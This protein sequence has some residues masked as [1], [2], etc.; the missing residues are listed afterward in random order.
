MLL[1]SSYYDDEGHRTPSGSEATAVVGLLSDSLPFWPPLLWVP[2]FHLVCSTPCCEA[3]RLPPEALLNGLRIATC[4]R[5]I[6]ARM[7]VF[8]AHG[9]YAAC[10]A[11]EDEL[12]P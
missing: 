10:P 7:L 5:C 11:C 12:R 8:A 4:S 9:L 1:P 2:L 6:S 3:L